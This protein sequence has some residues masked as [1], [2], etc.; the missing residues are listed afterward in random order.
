MKLLT[1]GRRTGAGTVLS[2]REQR[3][4]WRIT[5]LLLDYPN[6]ET[7]DLVSQL[8]A[9]TAELPDAARS[10]LTEFLRRFGETDPMQR[11]SNYV[12]TFDMRRR[13]SLHLTYYAYGDTRK[14][15]MA[16]LRFKHAY[17]QAGIEADDLGNSELPDY[18][19]MVLEF[20]AT[21]DHAQGER[22]LAEHVPVLELLRLS[23]QDNTSYYADVLAAVLTTLPPVNSADRRRIEQLAAEGPPEEDVGIDPFAMDPMTMDPT[24][25]GGRR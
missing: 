14:R 15:G 25:S 24:G 22:L 20:A 16:L 1:R 7:A 21:V 3:L 12:E 18:L 2:E 6:A 4:V 5:A 8:D 17:R 9:V 19:P 23:L 10:P 11:A 13:S